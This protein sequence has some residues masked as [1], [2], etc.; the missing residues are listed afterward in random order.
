M[1]LALKAQTELG[2][3]LVHRLGLGTVQFGQAYGISNT[4]GQ[5]PAT[6]VGLIL[7]LAARAGVGLIDTAANYGEA[8]K[9]LSQFDTGSFRT[10]TKTA[11][12][13]HGVDAVIARA[14]R[15][16]Q[17]LGHVDMLLVH[18]ASDLHSPNGP[19]LWRALRDLKEEGTVGGIGISAYVAEDPVA[20]AKTFQPDAMQLPFGLLDQRVAQNGTLARLKDMDVEIHAR[21]V[22]LQGLLFL[23]EPP[24]PLRHATPLLEGVHA[25]F[26]R[27][28]VTPLAA[29][30]GFVLSRS[31]VDVAVVGVTGHG[32]LEEILAAALAPLPE[33]D[34]DAC[35]LNDERVLTPSFW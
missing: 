24:E 28:N 10:V 32:Q 12:I 18:A 15:S 9:V 35:A 4:R 21:S 30:L 5:V 16:V 7:E 20:L 6:E 22:F 2:S 13:A 25:H 33:L 26:A 1:N 19:A 3:R 34:W 8:E 31:D 11:S 14:R 27:A 23:K 17:L 29:A